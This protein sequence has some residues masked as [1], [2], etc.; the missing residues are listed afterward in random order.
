MFRPSCDICPSR[1]RLNSGGNGRDA[2]RMYY[3][4]T[5]SNQVTGCG[6]S[7]PFTE[8]SRLA[9][10][11]RSKIMLVKEFVDTASVGDND[12]IVF[13]DAWDTMVLAES[14]DTLRQGFIAAEKKVERPIIFAPEEYCYPQDKVS[15]SKVPSDR[16]WQYGSFMHGY[17]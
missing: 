8:Y 10:S 17:L 7:E 12:L 13:V 2:R 11:L 6:G 4:V 9:R 15:P 3:G 5:F 16:K 14:S 1:R